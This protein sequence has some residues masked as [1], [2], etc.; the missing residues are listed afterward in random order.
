MISIRQVKAARALLGWSQDDLARQ[1]GVSY[2][3]VA[4]IE[5]QD[6]P[7]GGRVSTAEAIQRALEAGGVEFTNGGRP[8]VRLAARRTSPTRGVTAAADPASEQRPKQ[9]SRKKGSDVQEGKLARRA[10]VEK[11]SQAKA[12]KGK[13]R[14]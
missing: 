7:L 5:A 11:V 13:T 6:G 8:G 4:R 12:P 3:T 9:G 2:P 10:L 1:S 14:P